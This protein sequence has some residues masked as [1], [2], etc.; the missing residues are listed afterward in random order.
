MMLIGVILA[1]V[2]YNHIYS[3]LT[4]HFKLVFLIITIG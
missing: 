2:V 4:P 1:D 3:T